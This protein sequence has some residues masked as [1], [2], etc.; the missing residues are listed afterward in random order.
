MYGVKGR[1]MLLL[2]GL[3]VGH[4]RQYSVNLIFF[5]IYD[6]K[7]C[8]FAQMVGYNKQFEGVILVSGEL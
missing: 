7:V 1:E 4:S 3:I 6:S 2:D 8:V 5:Y